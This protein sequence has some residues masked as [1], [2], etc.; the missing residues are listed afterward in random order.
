M[1]LFEVAQNGVTLLEK[2]SKFTL[3]NGTEINAI[4]LG[5]SGRGRN[6]CVIPTPHILSNV[7]PATTKSGNIRLNITSTNT[8]DVLALLKPTYGF[9]GSVRFELGS[10]QPLVE[11]IVAQGDAGRMGGNSQY[12]LVLKEGENI[13][14]TR[15]GRLYG[16]EATFVVFNQGGNLQQ[17]PLNEYN[18]LN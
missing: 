13:T 3:K 17:L 1:K 18:L 7:V 4:F 5:E 6:L 14:Y 15:T 8:T 16:A 9:R 2:P 10:T 12:L 11:G